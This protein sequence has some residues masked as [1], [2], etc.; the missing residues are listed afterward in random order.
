[1]LADYE[2]EQANLTES[3]ASLRAEVEELKDKAA[4]LASF[5]ELI[6]GQSEITDLT[7]E[8]ARRYVDKVIVHEAVYKEGSK[9]IKVSQKVQVFLSCIG[10][11]EQDE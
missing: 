9:N 8:I 6:K 3:A 7:P 11:F 1:M 10:E 4:N 5:M 2:A